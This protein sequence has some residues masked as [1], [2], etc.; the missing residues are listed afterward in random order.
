M[1]AAKAAIF[2]ERARVAKPGACF[3]CGCTATNACPVEI[4]VGDRRVAT[5]GCMWVMRT[6]QRLCDAHP[7]WEVAAASRALKIVDEEAA[8]VA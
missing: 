1:N 6:K 4:K 2:L 3:L 5:R 7:S 8:R